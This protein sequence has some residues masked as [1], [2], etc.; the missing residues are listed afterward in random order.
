MDKRKGL[1]VKHAYSS[2]WINPPCKLAT[3]IKCRDIKHLPIC[4]SA[5]G[6]TEGKTLASQSALLPSLPLP[7]RRR[8]TP[9]GLARTVDGVGGESLSP[10]L[11][12]CALVLAKYCLLWGAGRRR[13]EAVA[14]SAW[15]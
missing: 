13:G 4:R 7:R 14:G 10:P 9:P 11:S 5:W 12:W 6:D 3:Y 8:R 15:R 2:W 1:S